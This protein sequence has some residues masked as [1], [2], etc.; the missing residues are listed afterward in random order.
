MSYQELFKKLT[1]IKINTLNIITKKKASHIGSNFSCAHLILAIY[2][3][4]IHRK[5]NIFLMSKGHASAVYYSTLK[6]FGELSSKKLYTFVNN[7]SYL[8]GHV[9][10][11]ANKLIP[12]SS[13]SLGN[14]IGVACGYAYG[15]KVFKKNRKIFVL[16]SDGEL[17]EGSTWES[18]IFASHHKLKNIIVILDS[19]K[20]QNIDKV[21]NVLDISD[22]KSKLKKFKWNATVVN[23]HNFISIYA[24]LN[25]A[26]KSKKPFFIIANTTKGKGVSFMENKILWHY[27]NPDHL[28]YKKAILELNNER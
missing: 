13:G 21:K 18:I 15:D 20:L 2:K 25:K 3:K 7:G 22:I 27:K 17:N 28:E 8:S 6:E 26:F 24:G 1:N 9:S 23:G 12:F 11:F 19:N 16:I 5:K 10:K 14:G 4:Y